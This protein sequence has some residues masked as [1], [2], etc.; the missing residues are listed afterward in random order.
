MPL[1]A[2][3]AGDR[4]AEYLKRAKM[5]QKELANALGIEPSYISRMVKG[6]INW[7]TGQYFGQIASRLRLADHEVKALNPAAVVEMVEAPRAA[8]PITD[9]AVAPAIPQA[10]LDAATLYQE[11]DPRIADPNVQLALA[12]AGYFG[13]GP[14]TPQD[15]IRYFNDVRNW[16]G[17]MGN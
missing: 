1:T 12:R 16:I 15:W 4:L 6:H 9:E 10:L 13:G 11:I 14:E 5:Q 7:T 2:D 17:R 3:E 8:P